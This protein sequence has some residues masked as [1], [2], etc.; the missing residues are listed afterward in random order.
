MTFAPIFLLAI[1]SCAAAFCLSYL[2]YRLAPQLQ[3]LQHANA[4]SSHIKPTATGGGVSFAILGLISG[5][6]LSIYQPAILPFV[7]FC[8]LLA[9]VGFLDDLMQVPAVWRFAVQLL[10]S[11]LLFWAA[12]I[13]EL[14]TVQFSPVLLFLIAPLAV[15]AAVWWLNLVNFMDGIDGL[16]ATQTATIV[17]CAIFLS[18]F[19]AGIPLGE[20]EIWAV[21]IVG[22]VLGFLLLNFPPAKIFMGDAGSYFIAAALL[23]MFLYS[24]VRSPQISA[25]WIVLAMPLVCDAT[26]TLI[27]RILQR[28]KWLAPHRQHVYQKLSRRW[29]SH[30]TATL[31]YLAAT[32]FIL[33]PMAALSIIQPSFVWLIL[34]LSYGFGMTICIALGAGRPDPT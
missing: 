27:V 10:T 23:S 11:I 15:V 8:S 17:L 18:F 20:I 5:F 2:L 28:Q 22:A 7:L 31:S 6:V 26:A 4:R 29:A 3:L 16:V 14:A 24:S 13:L 1:G 34:L 12:G 19:V 32:L 30:R 9:L 25:A 33:F 21:I